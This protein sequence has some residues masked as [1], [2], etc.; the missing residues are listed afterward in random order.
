MTN[1]RRSTRSR[2]VE[3]VLALAV[4]AGIYLLL[5]N[6]GASWAGEPFAGW[7]GA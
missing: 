1:G 2:T 3:I 5:V 6:G 7:F 4:V